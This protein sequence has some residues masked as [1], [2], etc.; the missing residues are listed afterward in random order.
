MATRSINLK[1]ILP[2][3]EA[4][5]PLRESIWLTHQAVNEAVAE[6]ER[7]LLLC[8]GRGYATGEDELVS[9]EQV[10]GEALGWAREVQRTNSKPDTDDDATVLSALTSLYEALI[11]SVLLDENGKP[12]EGDAQAA[13]AFASPIMDA[14][15][16]GFLCNFDKILEPPPVWV[17][18]M[19]EDFPS[20][21]AESEA[22]LETEQAHTLLH[23][24]NRP[25]TWVLL[26]RRGEPWQE[27]FVKDQEKK[28]KEDEGVP[29]LIRKLKGGLG[30]LPLMRPPISSRFAGWERGLTPWDRLALGL[31][32]AH[33]LSW[34]SWNHRARAEH[35]RVR[36]RVEK[37]RSAIERFGELI[38]RLREYESARHEKLKRVVEATDE[39]PFLITRRMVRAWDRVREEWLRTRCK[40]RD[41]RLT[42]LADLQTKLSGR[43]GDPNLFR[44]LA[45]DS[46]KELWQSED[47]L[48]ALAQ[49]N[50][51]ER[52]LGRK[53]E[54]ALYTPPDARLHPRWVGYEAKGGSNRRDYD[55]L[56]DQGQ[57]K[58]KLKLL[59][60]AVDGMEEEDF[61][62]PLAPS[63][64]LETPTWNGETKKARRL[65]FRS[66]Y[67]DFA[68]ALRGSDILLDR[69]HLESREAGRL[70]S[71][72]VG[73]VWFKLVLDIDSKAP[74]DWL[75]RRGRTITP[76]TV[77][78][79]NT[80][81]ANAS[82][83]AAALGPGLRVLSVDL[84]LRTFA[85]C[86]VFELVAGR[87]EGVLAFLADEE[88]DLWAR[89]ERSFM[90][91]LPGDVT[92]AEVRAARDRAYDEMGTIRRDLFRLRDLLRMSSEETPDE[93]RVAL[94]DMRRSLGEEWSAGSSSLISQD[95]LDS[96]G[97]MLEFPQP[98]WEDEVTKRFKESETTLGER[99][100]H[101]RQQTRPRAGT[102]EDRR[103]HRAYFGGKSVWAVQYL[104][105]VRRLLQGWSLHGRRARQINRADREKQGVFASNLLDHINALKND[106]VKAGSDLI[107][108]AARGFVPHPVRGWVPRFEPCRLILLEDLARYRF[109]TDR[110][111][112][113][114]SQ[115]MLWNH[116]Q[117]AAEVEMQ[118]D[119]YG[120][121][122]GTVGA[123]FSSRFH[124]RTGS[125][126]CRVR[127]LSD[128][129]LKSP[130]IRKRLEVLCEAVATTFEALRPGTTVPWD[131]GQEFVTLGPNGL[132]VTLHADINAA[133]NL[134]RRFWTRYA[135]AYRIS[136]LEVHQDETTL[137]YP[138]R[139]GSRLRGALAG[140]VGGK[141]YARLVPAADGDGF[142]LE[143]I[144][145]AQ[146][147]MGTG[148]RA[149][150][151]DGKDLDELEAELNQAVGEGIERAD[152]R[153]VFFRDASGLMLRSDRWYESKEFWGRVRG[154]VV[155]ALEIT[156]AKSTA[157]G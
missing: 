16:S 78:H 8:R 1:M 52:L 33:L 21:K 146:W 43:F 24:R 38:P 79:F 70:G 10:Q 56:L 93:R 67:Q 49:L 84:G 55:L 157:G 114:N 77:H 119:A 19:R 123:G 74:D 139:D 41:D 28:R 5:R 126:G 135:D 106:R 47:P 83:H 154:R 48:P 37:H 68:A 2:R 104:T 116:R 108:Q 26:S 4:G 75:D 58:V 133:Q 117:I 13:G 131:G 151:G 95:M 101:W 7:I 118:A 39:R 90:L 110:P 6:L 80:G 3:G 141:G 46:R 36:E 130:W 30:L 150:S 152:G 14:E 122:T 120:V 86:S 149:A 92:S 148:S 112:R 143:A 61:L 18:Q 11:P 128:E 51:L 85:A 32:V 31:A 111:R 100:R 57:V 140:Q 87:P 94:D 132:A 40:T 15:S 17:Q 76:A 42:V 81:R 153:K 34:E 147:Q 50:A 35:G 142:C 155:A 22:W 124:A 136:A 71:G 88:R 23:A 129:D 98:M 82:R 145:R 109:R 91:S 69:R 107:V 144:S 9:A 137:W 44:W 138:D 53:R 127:Q 99:L 97:A 134:Q 63:G 45:D 25:S 105:G 96:L 20:W 121:V 66:A 103:S 125:P 29:S 60:R 72:D 65:L 73:Q 12:L 156:K 54:R 115:L 27:S 102:L 89:H 59:G 113:E 64:Q 62:I